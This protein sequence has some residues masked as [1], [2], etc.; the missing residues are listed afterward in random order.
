V[1]DLNDDLEN[2]DQLEPDRYRHRSTAVARAALCAKCEH[3]TIEN[4]HLRTV[5]CQLGLRPKVEP[6]G[7]GWRA[8]C[9]SF[10]GSPGNQS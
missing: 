5:R 10:R 1:N 6:E 7:Q 4:H 8:N 9:D 2:C 3:Y